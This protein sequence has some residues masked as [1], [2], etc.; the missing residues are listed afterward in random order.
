MEAPALAPST[1]MAAAAIEGASAPSSSTASATPVAPKTRAPKEKRR[2]M[3]L[4]FIQADGGAQKVPDRF[5]ASCEQYAAAPRPASGTAGAAP[6]APSLLRGCSATS[7]TS[8][9]ACS[10]STASAQDQIAAANAR[11]PMQSG[12]LTMASEGASTTAS[13]GGEQ[14]EVAGV[15]DLELLGK[16]GSGSSGFVEKHRH[17][18]TGRELALKV[19]QAKD[20]SEAQRKA[21]LL[22]LR[23]F[24]KC[25]SPHIV[26]FYGAFFHA[27]S[28][29][30]ALE[31]MDAGALSCVLERQ[32]RRGGPSA[33]VVPE[34]ILANVMWQILDGLE[35]LHCEMR[36]IHRDIKPANLLFSSSGV[37]KITDFGVSGELEDDLASQNK[38]TFVGTMYYMS[39]ERVRGEP[40]KYDSDMWSLGVTIFECAS[41]RYPYA[42]ADEDSMRQLS[43]WE[44]MR[45]I[46][47]QQAPCLPE[48][49]PDGQ[50]R[51]SP[52]LQDIA[53][54]MLK[55]EPRNRPSAAMMKTHA[56]F[57]GSWPPSAAQNLEL[58]TW[59]AGEDTSITPSFATE[60]QRVD[61]SP[62]APYGFASTPEAREAPSSSGS[63]QAGT[64]PFPPS[65]ASSSSSTAVP[66]TNA[67]LSEL[68]VGT[69]PP[70]PPV[71]SA[72]GSSAAS[73]PSGPSMAMSVRSGGQNLFRRPGSGGT[74][75]SANGAGAPSFPFSS[76]TSA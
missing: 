36:V 11:S 3:Q 48:I 13:S 38:V 65:G 30:I 22:E 8:S 72:V 1:P 49:G 47:E 39:P 7:A 50:H 20:V 40:Y 61:I 35:Y 34:R 63:Q 17:V 19:I 60:A 69:P 45:R 58:A 59:V 74:P 10:P 62:G 2:P 9:A 73:T 15:E 37:A 28:I 43:F 52:E 76:E 24:A 16:L 64:L 54:Q 53:Q 4:S 26:D 31:Y 27:S 33:A 21:I 41:G 68:A 55:K 51:N 67:V 75:M 12:G 18:R 29:H 14:A 44:L 57:G 32:R 5:V 42:K 25:R 56:W 70:L 23:T 71:G 6:G 66:N 46:V